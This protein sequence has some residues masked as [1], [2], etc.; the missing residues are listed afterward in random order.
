LDKNI[1]MLSLDS[2]MKTKEEISEALNNLTEAQKYVLLLSYYDGLTLGQIAEKLNIP[3]P[4]VRT[5]I[6]VA[7]NKLKENLLGG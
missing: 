2:A 3:V 7:L 4:T 5:K 1:D 6:M